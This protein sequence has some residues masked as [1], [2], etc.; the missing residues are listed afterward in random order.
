VYAGALKRGPDL[1]GYRSWGAYLRSGKTYNDLAAAVYSSP[2]S[3]QKLGQGDVR[4]WVDGLYRGLLGRGAGASE[5]ASWAAQ[6]AT[7]G[8]AYV[9]ITIAKSLEARQRRV[10]GYYT[11]LMQRG[12][13]SAGLRTWVP[14][15]LGNGDIDVQVS[16][17]SSAEYWNRAG[18]RFP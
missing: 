1:S 15:L 6:A 18:V 11:E 8:R 3:L 5:R 4:L 10:N 7:R 2:E 9:A 13:D 14:L 16:L 17:I 12:V